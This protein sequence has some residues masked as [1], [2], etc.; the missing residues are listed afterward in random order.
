[1]C[2]LC[3]LAALCSPQG[4]ENKRVQEKNGVDRMELVKMIST[5][6]LMSVFSKW[7][8]ELSR[9]INKAKKRIL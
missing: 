3:G 5:S 1:M 8:K 9:F 2:L 4:W 6:T 7:L